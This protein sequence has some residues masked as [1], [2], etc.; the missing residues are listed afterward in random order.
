MQCNIG[1]CAVNDFD[2]SVSLS[3]RIALL[4]F[5]FPVFLSSRLI[6]CRPIPG[7]FPGATIQTP[8]GEARLVSVR[9]D[10]KHEATLVKDNSKVMIP[11]KDVRLY[12]GPGFKA[13]DEVMT[14]YGQGYIESTRP[15]QKDLVVKLRFWKLAQGQSPTLYLH[16]SS[17]VKIHG[18]GVGD[19]AKTVWGVVRITGMR[20]DGT[21]I[22][23]A[24]HWQL[25]DKKPPTMYLAPEAFALLSIKP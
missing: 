7:A 13:G 16:P 12:Q 18:F 11:A 19:C 25:A 10:S 1:E 4:A 21:Y 23:E 3:Y 24:L 20:R 5:L 2:Y 8:K 22:C 9:D 6:D 15:K 17:C 14:V